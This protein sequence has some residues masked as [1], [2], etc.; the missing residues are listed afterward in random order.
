[1][2]HNTKSHQRN[3]DDAIT[4]RIKFVRKLIPGVAS[5]VGDMAQN[6]EFSFTR[7]KK[8]HAATMCRGGTRAVELS[9]KPRHTVTVV[10]RMK[11]MKGTCF[12]ESNSIRNHATFKNFNI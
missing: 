6:Q 12:S 4:A 11:I 7:S 5:Y 10:L 8:T 2:N 3:H 9:W 1:M